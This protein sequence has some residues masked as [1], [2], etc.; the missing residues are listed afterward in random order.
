MRAINHAL[1]GSIIGL[2]ISQSE[3]AIPLALVSHFICDMIPHY[4]GGR[5]AKAE[6]IRSPLFQRLLY[7]DAIL[8]GLLVLALALKHPFHWQLAAICAFV[9]AAPDMASI[10]QYRLAKSNKALR[11]GAYIR[12]A[13]GIQWFERPIGAVVD[14]VWFIAGVFVV[15][16]FLR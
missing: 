2:T 16:I 14:L 10:G 13:N 6:E 5:A 3:L 1:T 12:F 9:A 7:L 4:G 15:S 11:P 8:C